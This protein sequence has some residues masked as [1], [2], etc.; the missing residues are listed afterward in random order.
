[1]PN[2]EDSGNKY[3]QLR[4]SKNNIVVGL[5]GTCFPSNWRDRFIEALDERGIYWYNPNKLNGWDE[6]REEYMETERKHL[7][8]DDIILFPITSETYSTGSLGE[9]GYSNITAL[10]QNI[11]S[12]H[13]QR[14]IIFIDS[15][16]TD[17]LKVKSPSAA[18]E[19]RRG[20]ALVLNK[21]KS[22]HSPNIIIVDSLDKMLDACLSYS[23]IAKLEKET[24]QKFNKEDPKVIESCKSDMFDTMLKKSDFGLALMQAPQDKK[25]LILEN[26][27]FMYFCLE[28]QDNAEIIKAFL[29]LPTEKFSTLIKHPEIYDNFAQN[30]ATRISRNKSR[31]TIPEDWDKSSM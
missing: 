1:M 18:E 30:T 22:I 26:I 10:E 23:E 11:S 29:N 20:R 13:T 31:S 28:I 21:L 27:E 4:K 25:E 6:H 5:F 2:I 9:T 17:E 24:S 3:A 16:V 8:Q 14:I 7:Q 19:S 12:S 15:D